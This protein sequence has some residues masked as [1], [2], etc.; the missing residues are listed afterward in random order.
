MKRQSLIALTIVSALAFSSVAS[1]TVNGGSNN[2]APGATGQ[3]TLITYATRAGVQ[4]AGFDLN[5]V[6]N[7]NILID[8]SVTFQVFDAGLNAF[9]TCDGAEHAQSFTLQI[10]CDPLTGVYSARTTNNTDL[11][12]LNN[13]MRVLYN[14][15]AAAPAGGT[16]TLAFGPYCMAGQAPATDGCVAFFDGAAALVANPTAPTSNNGTITV[17]AGTPPTLTFAPAGGTVASGA[18]FSTTGSGG[19][20]GGIA[21]Y[22]CT[23]AGGVTVN[24]GDGNGNGSIAFGVVAPVVVN[25]SCPAG[26]DGSVSCTHTGGAGSTASPV[27]YTIDC[28]DVP[29]AQL[30]SNT[31]SGT[32]LFCDGAPGSQVTTGVTLTNP[33]TA[34][35]TGVAC[36]VGGAGFV[37]TTPPSAT[38]TAGGGSSNVVVTCT[39][40]AAGAGTAAGTLTCDAANESPATTLT[41]PLSSTGQ[42][43]PVFVVPDVIPAN[44]LWSKLG[45]IGLLAALGVLAVAFRRHH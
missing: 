24:D 45:L 40:P 11:P 38:I 2:V 28:P 4:G 6:E 21:N 35:L 15:E 5:I 22:T 18:S 33:G 44:S 7:Q 39:V 16:A 30:S 32:T 3:T 42:T 23:P 27:N 19:T 10:G 12:D 8:A 13:N 17:A 25:V 29:T 41:F 9:V 14:V 1:A 20:A 26:P 36:V 31:A 43:V 37:L 34:D